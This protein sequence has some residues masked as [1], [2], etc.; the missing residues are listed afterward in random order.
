MKV[1]LRKDR[2]IRPALAR[3]C[4][5]VGHGDGGGEGTGFQRK[6]FEGWRPG[7]GRSDLGGGLQG[8][9]EAAIIVWM[10]QDQ[11]AVGESSSGFDP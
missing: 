10:A 5:R 1:A 8:E 7:I 9:A 11:N 3:E 6:C 2:K 4:T